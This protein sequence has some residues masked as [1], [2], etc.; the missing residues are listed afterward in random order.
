VGE[1]LPLL[2][3]KWSVRVSSGA[4]SLVA[5]QA[6]SCGR[7]SGAVVPRSRSN[8]GR[9][10]LCVEIALQGGRPRRGATCGTVALCPFTLRRVRSGRDAGT[11]PPVVWLHERRGAR[12]KRKSP[13]RAH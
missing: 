1:R 3:A 12:R 4:L 6:G 10:K 11:D 2:R 9:P 13:W 5:E 8:V 7:G